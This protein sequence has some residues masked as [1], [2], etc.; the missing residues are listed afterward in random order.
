[1]PKVPDLDQSVGPTMSGPS[2]GFASA[3]QLWTPD[4]DKK[5]PSLIEQEILQ[6]A[7]QTRQRIAGLG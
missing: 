5:P 4:M 1:M 2:T 6:V 7:E 3:N